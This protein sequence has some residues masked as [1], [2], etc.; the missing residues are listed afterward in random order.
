[1]LNDTQLAKLRE[2]YAHTFTDGDNFLVARYVRNDEGHAVF[3]VLLD[4]ENTCEEGRYIVSCLH[5]HFNGALMQCICDWEA[6]PSH[7]S[8]DLA[9]ARAAFN[10]VK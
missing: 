3:A 8:N 7:C 6:H 1:M 9:A 2:I 4:A 5:V 10:A